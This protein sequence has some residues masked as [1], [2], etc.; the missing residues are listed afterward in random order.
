MFYLSTLWTLL[1]L[2]FFLII[3][4]C[5]LFILLCGRWMKLRTGCEIQIYINFYAS[6]LST[7]TV[8][9]RK[10]NKEFILY[11]P[12]KNLIQH[13]TWKRTSNC[14]S[15]SWKRN[16]LFPLIQCFMSVSISLLIKFSSFHWIHK[17][18]C[19]KK[20]KLFLSS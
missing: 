9:V 16:V 17:I 1:F 13:F 18:F 4:L 15:K 6:L 19:Q 20:G 14:S 5:F 2:Y 11:I 3:F 8:Y 10:L 7:T 12:K